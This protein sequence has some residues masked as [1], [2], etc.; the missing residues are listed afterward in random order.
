M[1]NL[2]LSFFF[3]IL[4]LSQNAVGNDYH[5]KIFRYALLNAYDV[6]IGLCCQIRS[7]NRQINMGFDYYIYIVYVETH[8]NR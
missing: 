5:E 7:I 3:F 1:S 8:F 6:V 2:R 4:P